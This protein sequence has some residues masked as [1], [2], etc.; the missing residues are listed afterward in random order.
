MKILRSGATFGIGMNVYVVD[1]GE[2][3]D[4]SN[5]LDG[6]ILQNDCVELS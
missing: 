2:G 4:H 1:L 6:L 5:F 3:E